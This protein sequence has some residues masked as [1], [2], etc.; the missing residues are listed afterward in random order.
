MTAWRCARLGTSAAA[1]A[2]L[3]AATLVRFGAT[4]EPPSG[5]VAVHAPRTNASAVRGGVPPAREEWKTIEYRGVQI[6]IPSAWH[7]PDMRDCE[8]E[9]ARWAPAESSSCRFEGGVAFYGSATFCPAYGPGIRQTAAN[10]LTAATWS[11][12]VY[13]GDFA[14]Y[15]R[16]KDRNLVQEVLGSAR[17]T[18][19]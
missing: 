2:T 13:A 17:E 4:N 3:V 15:A 16:D 18:K 12:Y 10:G 11:G 14:V 5:L 6:D 7:R 8:F 1:C 9:P 19:K